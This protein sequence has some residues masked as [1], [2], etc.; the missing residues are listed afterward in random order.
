MVFVLPPSM[1]VLAE[2]LRGRATDAE[3]TIQRRLAKA[4]DELGHYN[5][6]EYLIVNDD[7]E[8]AYDRLRAV[9]L[10][11]TCRWDR[12]SPKAE[13]LIHEAGTPEFTALSNT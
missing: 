8:T 12:R 2:R 3:A 11:A 6:Y 1:T 5:A 9:Y 13:A 10:A 4:V 7:L